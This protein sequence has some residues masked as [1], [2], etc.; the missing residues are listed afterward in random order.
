MA[1]KV[2]LK[3]VGNWSAE[4]GV[5][6]N[7]A[8]AVSMDICGR[9]GEQACR[10]AMILMAQSAGK[11]MRKTRRKTR[12]IEHDESGKYVTVYVQGRKDPHKVYEWM[13]KADRAER[14]PGQW[15]NARKIGNIGLGARSWMWGLGKLGAKSRISRA[16]PGGSRVFTITGETAQGYVKQNRLDYVTKALP[17]GWQGTVERMAGNKIMEQARRKLETKW[18]R[19]MGMPGRTRGAAKTPARDLSKYFLKG[20]A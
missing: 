8:L 1:G 9:T 2:S 13:F 3:M 15:A 16:I 5:P 12:Q 11:L 6:L 14:I 4:L 18:R 19:E 20:A 17:A 7:N 10:H